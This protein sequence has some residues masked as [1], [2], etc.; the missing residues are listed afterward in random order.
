MLSKKNYTDASVVYSSIMSLG[1]DASLGNFNLGKLFYQAGD[2]Q[3]VIYSELTAIPVAKGKVNPKQIQIDATQAKMFGY[4]NQ[5]DSCFAIVNTLSPTY[6]TGFM[7]RGRIQS[8]LDPESKNV[9]GKEFYEKTISIMDA[10]VDKSKLKKA[11]I[12]SYNYLGS[13]YYFAFER[14][15]GAEATANKELSISYFKRF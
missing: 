1:G 6:A 2:E 3:R 13:Y 10:A 12:E 9:K 5:A 14:S 11:Y 8:I 4:Y 15:K 7:W